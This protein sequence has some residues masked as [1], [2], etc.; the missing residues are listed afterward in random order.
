MSGP[1]AA[2]HDAECSSDLDTN[3]FP[4]MPSTFQLPSAKRT[5]CLWGLYTTLQKLAGFKT[6]SQDLSQHRASHG[7]PSHLAKSD[8]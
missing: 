2:G 7:I 3:R 1:G 5:Q 4:N 8:R 6:G